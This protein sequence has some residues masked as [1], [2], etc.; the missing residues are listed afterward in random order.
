L[1]RK[2]LLQTLHLVTQHISLT[3]TQLLF[4]LGLSLLYSLFYSLVLSKSGDIFSAALLYFLEPFP[5][6][7]IVSFQANY[8]HIN[9]QSND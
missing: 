4:V 2:E 7:K 8:F 1:V 5:I 6:P 9:E 3:I